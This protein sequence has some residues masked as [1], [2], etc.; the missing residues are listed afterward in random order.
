MKNFN[1]FLEPSNAYT[2]EGALYPDPSPRNF[3]P[4]FGPLAPLSFVPQNKF[5]LM[6]LIHKLDMW[7]NG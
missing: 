5:G 3:A 7:T 1:N 6:P 4:C 2:A